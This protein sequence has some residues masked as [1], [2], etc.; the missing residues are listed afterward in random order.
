MNYIFKT[1]TYILFSSL[2]FSCGS[3]DGEL[4]TIFEGT[5]NS[6]SLAKFTI[7]N[8]HLYIV[9]EGN[10]STS[11]ISNKTIRPTNTEYIGGG[12]ETIFALDSLLLLGTRSGMMIYDIYT[13]PNKPTLKSFKPHFYSCDP[14]TAKDTIAYVT[15]N[16][17]GTSCHFGK[18]QL[19]VYSIN[20][21][22]NPH[23][24]ERIDMESPKGLATRGDF[25]LVADEGLK[26][27]STAIKESLVLLDH[28][29]N[30]NAH[31]IISGPKSWIVIGTDGIKQY[32][33]ENNQLKFIS[34]VVR[35]EN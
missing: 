16:S 7:S 5:G 34:Q 2:L 6:G 11:D 10:L 31:D 13:E 30:I 27:Y 15:L 17:A 19:E 23:L 29:K 28:Q 14:V 24:I 3:E 8:N 26:L 9:K 32:E 1:L 33:I 12:V 25:L 22:E 4:G 18:N 20:D 35:Y 21:I